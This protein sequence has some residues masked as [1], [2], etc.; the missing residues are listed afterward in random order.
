MT[1]GVALKSIGKITCTLVLLVA[2]IYTRADC[3][4]EAGKK[5]YNKCIACHSVETDVQLM[6]PSLHG[7][8]GREVGSVA[9]FPFSHAMETADFLWTEETLDA[10]IERPMQYLPGTVMPFGGIRKAVQREALI[11]YIKQLD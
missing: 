5:Q 9:D 1:G 8:M 7:L 11:C 3:D 6:G 10:F 4:V 2:S